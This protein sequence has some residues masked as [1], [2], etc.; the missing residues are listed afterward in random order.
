MPK[1]DYKVESKEE[2]RRLGK[3]GSVETL[4]R[5]WATSRGGTYFHVDVT[6]TAL[7]S[8]DAV[9]TARAKEL[10]AL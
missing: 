5:I 2:I 10:D 4:F 9:L 3:G 6:E 8:S 1:G 7:T